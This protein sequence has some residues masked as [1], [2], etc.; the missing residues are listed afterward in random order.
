[1]KSMFD[2][3]P[4]NVELYIITSRAEIII[5]RDTHAFTGIQGCCS[6]N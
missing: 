5:A 3:V 4:A 6:K 2:E 1:M